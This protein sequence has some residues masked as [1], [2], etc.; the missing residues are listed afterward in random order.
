MDTTA[1]RDDNP[2]LRQLDQSRNFATELLFSAHI[3][4]PGNL[5]IVAKKVGSEVIGVSLLEDDRSGFFSENVE[6]TRDVDSV[7]SEPLL[8][9]A[10]DDLAGLGGLSF[11]KARGRDNERGNDAV[12]TELFDIFH[13]FLGGETRQSGPA[14]ER[15]KPGE[16]RRSHRVSL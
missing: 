2:H 15:Q 16:A 14:C 5:G 9:L 7:P 10:K 12:W 13:D 6:R 11:G 4:L 8:E 1:S 3:V